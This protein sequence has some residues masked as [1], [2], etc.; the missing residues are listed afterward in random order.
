MEVDLDLADGLDA[1]RLEL[2]G[3]EVEGL[4]GSLAG[5]DGA[6]RCVFGWITR[7]DFILTRMDGG[8]CP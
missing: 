7:Y 3:R 4:V 1:G 5:R 2:G 8:H 6:S